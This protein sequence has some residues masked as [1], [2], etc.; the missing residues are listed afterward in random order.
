M[1]FVNALLV[2]ALVQARPICGQT[3][4]PPRFVSLQEC[5]R[6]ALEHNLDVQIERYT[7]QI[8][9]LNLDAAYGAY[10]PNFTLSAQDDSRSVPGE[11]DPK[12]TNPDV[13]YELN[14]ELYSSSLS[15]R[16]PTGMSYKLAGTTDFLMADTQLTPTAF[17][18]T[19][20]RHTN[21]YLASAALVLQQPLLKDFWIDQT[22]LTIRINK[23]N[24]RIAE[25]ALRQQLINTVAKVQ[26]AYYELIFAREKVKV[27][28]KALELTKQLLADN[29]IRLQAGKL[30]PLEEKQ[31]E[32]QAATVEAD[33]EAARQALADQQNVLKGL[34]NDDFRSWPDIVL[35]PTEALLAVAQPFVRSE[36][37]EKAMNLRPDLA[38]M[39]VDV[40]K[41]DVVVRYNFNQLFPSLDLVGSYGGLAVRDTLGGALGDV[42]EVA[43]PAYSYGVVLSLPLSNR[44]QRNNYRASQ[45]AKKQALLQQKKLEQEILMQVDNAG[46]L[47]Q[48]AYRRVTSTHQARVFAE[49]ALEAEN[50]KLTA[51]LSTSFIVLQ[52]QRNLTDARLAEIRASADY[53]KALVQLGFSEGSLLERNRLYLDTK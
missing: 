29:R 24:L 42:G 22:R 10:D 40:E 25:L 46:R 33:L 50:L 8:A 49:A 6:M 12:R 35:E 41:K 39:R 3:N 13:P 47:T 21:E 26:V 30:R 31:T 51:G 2:F 44:T 11:I 9:R 52:L 5:L 36:S 7:P 18:P 19:G 45:A 38:Q 43:N 34:I 32:S 20:L 16:L 1:R 37:W 17:Y 48:T 14:Q 15:G 4:F 28:Q 27:V 53:Q 23:K